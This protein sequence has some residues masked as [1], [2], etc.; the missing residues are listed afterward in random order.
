MLVFDTSYFFRPDASKVEK[1]LALRTLLDCLIDLNLT[2]L[3][4]HSAPSLYRSG[5]RYKRD[6]VWS[7]IPSLYQNGTGDC[8][9]LACALVA[10]YRMQGIA[11]QPAFR[12][13]AP[14]F[15]GT[16]LEYTLF[17]ILV[18]MPSGLVEDPSKKLGMLDR[19]L[20]AFYQPDS[21]SFSERY[22]VTE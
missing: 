11:A 4:Y 18:E 3:Q 9:S 10:E 5:V 15:K 17:H 20:R 22:G 13:Q 16:K 6:Q 12:F 8:K 1:A 14:F 2:F 19:D 7:P 21:S